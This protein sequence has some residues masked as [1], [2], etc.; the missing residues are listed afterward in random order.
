MTFK[1]MPLK[2]E[3]GYFRSPGR[4]GENRKIAWP[5]FSIGRTNMRRRAFER[6]M[7]QDYQTIFFMMIGPKENFLR[8][9]EVQA[10]PKNCSF[11]YNSDYTKQPWEG[12]PKCENYQ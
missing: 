8:A 10:F 4:G 1:K 3:H 7:F 5:L 11:C 2:N 9:P 12:V 6:F